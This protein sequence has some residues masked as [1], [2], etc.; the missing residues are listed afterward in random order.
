M[1]LVVGCGLP[2][3]EQA[4]PVDSAD[5]PYGLLDADGSERDGSSGSES[6]SLDSPSVVWVDEDERL[7]AV[8]STDSRIQGDT[9]DQAADLL[10]DLS[11]GPDAV[12]RADGLS[13]VLA[14]DARVELVRLMGGSAWV[15]VDPG[16]QSPTPERLPIAL[17]QIVLT[18]TSVPAIDAVQFVTDGEPI[19]VPLPGGELTAEPVTQ[20]DYSVLLSPSGGN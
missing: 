4:R 18:A 9:A 10:A 12:E 1:G 17:G 2:A 19:Q 6:T 5:V 3:D 8:E 14:P 7:V 20:S 16:T 13:T 15:Q 11:G